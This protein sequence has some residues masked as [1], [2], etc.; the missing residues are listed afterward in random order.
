MGC[1][2]DVIISECEQ[3]QQ[4][5][6]SIAHESEIDNII[7]LNWGAWMVFGLNSSRE[8]ASKPLRMLIEDWVSRL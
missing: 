5:E 3:S 8:T 2:D 4:V 1:R 6:K 7:N